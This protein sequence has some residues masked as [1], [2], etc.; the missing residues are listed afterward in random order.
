MKK[1]IFLFVLLFFSV[2]PANAWS[3]KE[4]RMMA[5]MA[6]EHLTENTKEFLAKYLDQSI[7]EYSVWMDIYRNAPGYAQT[8]KW[9]M[10]TVGEDGHSFPENHEGKAAQALEQACEILSNY[11]E[12][13]DSTIQINIIFLIHLVPEIHCPAHY[14]F[15]E[16]G[17]DVL[18]KQYTF[19]P[20]S[21][22]GVAYT[23]HKLWD[24]APTLARKDDNLDMAKAYYDIWDD[25]KRKD[26]SDG[27]IQA[28]LLDNA[29]RIKGIYQW[30]Q[31][32]QAID[33]QFLL[34]RQDFIDTQVRLGSARL[35]RI[36][37]D[38]FDKW[39]EKD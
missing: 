5:Y 33:R 18:T 9:H 23:Y 24:D 36:L 29:Q 20:I 17:D 27:G 7:V 11:K 37:N 15:L 1:G 30:I 2:S 10:V 4:H 16:F 34:D 3:D 22:N 35:E 13:N 26:V 32:G 28:W 31:K 21:Y 25:A 39:K 19:M 38:L 6:E 12:Y 8:T 14:Y